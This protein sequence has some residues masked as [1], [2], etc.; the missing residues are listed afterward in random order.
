MPYTILLPSTTPFLT[1]R[2]WN[3]EY[4]P[5]IASRI[6]LFVLIPAVIFL[7]LGP[8]ALLRLRR[9]ASIVD[10][11]TLKIAKLVGV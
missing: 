9:K 3:V 11:S 8:L 10:G 6:Y 1:R 7:L 4:N 5:G 2:S